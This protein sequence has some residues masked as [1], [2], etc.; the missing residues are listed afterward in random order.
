M[1]SKTEDARREYGT[2]SKFPG[3]R[4]GIWVIRFY[5][6]DGRRHTESTGERGKA[7]ET[8][9]RRL[10]RK[11]LGEVDSG[12][13]APDAK[14][15]RLS[16]L[17]QLVLDD[18][19]LNAR[20]STRRVRAAFDHLEEYFGHTPVPSIAR[21]MP[22]YLALRKREEAKPGTLRNEAA[23]L[24]RG[25][26]LA[27]KAGILPAMP[28]VETVAPAE[29]RKGFVPAK[30]VNA[31]ERA[32]PDYLRPYCRF[33]YLSGWR[34]S[35]AAELE[36]KHVDL[37]RGVIEAPGGT[38]NKK[39]PGTLPFHS[40]PRLDHLIR[41]QRKRTERWQ[42]EHGEIVQLVF[43]RPTPK[44]ARPVGDFRDEWAA[45]VKAAGR[46]DTRVHDFRRTR[47]TLWDQAG[48]S[49]KEAMTLGG[50]SAPATYLGYVQVPQS[51]LEGALEK[52]AAA[53]GADTRTRA[54]RGTKRP[55]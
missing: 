53:E 1:T 34:R 26:R 4:D 39:A 15:L 36:W 3:K 27:L 54:A 35:K 12:K 33:L 18:Y 49:M 31:I 5:G 2:G 47:A 44:G 45:A 52:A 37:D 6:D 11:R 32:L 50:W 14:K 48:V 22:E 8:A 28:V 51:S 42:K 9:A 41:E 24:R 19:E 20:V 40:D 46:P 17:R 7:G 23:A 25:C 38:A 10:L 16:D 43:W 21:R 55:R 29:P 13:H 30:A